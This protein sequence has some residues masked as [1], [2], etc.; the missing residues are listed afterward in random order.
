MKFVR[1]K[2]RK[3]KWVIK[4]D[5]FDYPSIGYTIACDV[6][7]F[8]TLVTSWAIYDVKYNI[9]ESM[10]VVGKY[11]CAAFLGNTRSGGFLLLIY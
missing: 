10:T 6:A 8:D 7:P 11:G 5:N 3:G 9:A 4:F 1:N 2:R